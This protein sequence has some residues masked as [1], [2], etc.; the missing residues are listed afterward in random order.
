MGRHIG[1]QFCRCG[2][3]NL[4]VNHSQ[5]FPLAGQAQHGFGKVSTTRRINPTGSENQV[6]RAGGYR[7]LAFKLGLTIDAQWP[8]D[9]VL[10]PGLAAAAVKHVVGRIMHQ[11]GTKLLRFSGQHARGQRIEGARQLRLSLGL[12]DGGV[13][14]RIDDNVGPDLTH[15][16]RQAG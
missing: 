9:I 3:A 12:V 10:A 13:G 7:L 5:R 4:V 8:G 16:L 11:P 15:G 6:S 2:R 1:Q 14:S